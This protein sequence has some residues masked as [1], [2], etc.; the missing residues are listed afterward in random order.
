VDENVKDE[1]DDISSEFAAEGYD[2][3]S[4]ETNDGFEELKF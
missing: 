2:E 4:G 1:D 3:E